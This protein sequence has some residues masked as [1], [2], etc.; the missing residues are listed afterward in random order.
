M[1]QCKEHN[2]R[3]GKINARGTQLT[4]WGKYTGKVRD[5]RN[6]KFT[7]TSSGAKRRDERY[8]VPVFTRFIN[9]AYV[10]ERTDSLVAKER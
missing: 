5:L 4:T 1:L 9:K 8:I 10:K 7:I 2:R 3:S 6:S